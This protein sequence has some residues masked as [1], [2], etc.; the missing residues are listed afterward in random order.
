MEKVDI[1]K[2]FI[3][4]NGLKF[5]EGRRNSDLVVLCGYALYIEAD[6]SDLCDSI[7]N[8]VRTAELGTELNRVSEYAENNNYGDWWENEDNRK[9]YKL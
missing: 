4:D 7:P 9:L 5:T 6:D 3:E 8:A 2:K 1:L